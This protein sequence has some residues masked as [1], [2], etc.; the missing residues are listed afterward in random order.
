V[1]G[2]TNYKIKQGMAW[3][4]KHGFI[5]KDGNHNKQNEFIRFT[6]KAGR[7]YRSG[8]RGTTKR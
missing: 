8:A 2:L 6:T 5:H 7:F 4:L 3:L 1:A